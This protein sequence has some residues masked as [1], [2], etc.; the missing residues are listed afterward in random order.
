M[1]NHDY[2][3]KVDLPEGTSGAVTIERF[4]V[5]R[6]YHLKRMEMAGRGTP[7]GEYTALRRNG[8]LWMSDTQA[9]W[10]DHIDAFYAMKRLGG[11]VLIN[12]LG[13]GM[14]VKAALA[15][16]NVEHVDVV[17][18]DEDV[19]KLVGPTYASERCTIHHADAYE[20]T[21]LWKPGTRWTVAWHDI[22]L[23][24]CE[25]NLS[26]MTKLHRSYGHRTD[27]QGSWARDILLDR[28]RRDGRY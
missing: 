20:Q 12:G 14:V 6:N 17:E 13:I 25:D 18:I 21:K 22:W 15:L 3:Y 7:V 5:E 16:P 8:S 4:Q 27:W 11:R 28:R 1:N 19:I 10:Y 24:M 23:H 26:E 9:E 2:D